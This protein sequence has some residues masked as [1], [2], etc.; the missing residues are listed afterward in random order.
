MVYYVWGVGMRNIKDKYVEYLESYIP[1]ELKKYYN[2]PSLQRLKHVGYFCGMDY[3][4]KN[5]YDFLNYVSTYDHSISTSGLTAKFTNDKKAILAALF[6]DI[7]KPTCSHVI[8]Y[9]N[10]DYEKQETTEEYTKDIILGDELLCSYLSEDKIKPEEIIDFK[11][12]SIVDC[13]RPKLCA[14]RIDGIILSSLMWSK[15]LRLREVFSIINDLDLF[16]NEDN[17][18]ELGFKNEYMAKYFYLRNRDIDTLTHSTSDM[19]MMNLLADIISSS[20]K[21]ELITYESLY[22]LTDDLLFSILSKSDNQE[23]IEKLYLFKTIKPREIKLESIY[24]VKKRVIN[25]L[26]NGHR[27]Y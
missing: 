17:E 1:E 11:A 12:Y 2:V 5:I 20:I 8:D 9:L 3:A 18:L 22:Y 6:H 10:K 23:I 26:V 24:P 14:D 4:S 27:L 21:D 16:K 25:P 7:S 13:R 15:T 19:Y